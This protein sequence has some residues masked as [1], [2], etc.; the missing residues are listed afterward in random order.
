MERE[1]TAMFIGHSDCWGISKDMV[2]MEIVKLI[3]KGVDTFLNGGMGGFDRFCIS[4]VNEIKKQY[5]HIKHYLVIPYLDFTRCK[6]ED[7]DEVLY[8]ALEKY[9][10]KAAI[11][12]RN[13]WM[14][15]NSG[16]ALCYVNHGFGGAVNTYLRAKRKKLAI[17]NLGTY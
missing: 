7:F 10:Y 15:D 1:K 17:V 13:N 5:P 12:K 9:Q 8:P 3:N 2:D 4:R 16:F 6:F 14:V 11:P